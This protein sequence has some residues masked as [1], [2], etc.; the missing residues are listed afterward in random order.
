MGGDAEGVM[1]GLELID[2]GDVHLEV[3]VTGSGESV[4]VIQTA[5]TADE[6]R[7]VAQRIAGS[8]DYQVLHYHRAD[9]PAA[10]RYVACGRW[11]PMLPMPG[12]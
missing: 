12:R 7:P 10:V 9:M 2:V 1:N 5:L 3:E 4:V 8:G 6:L 11:R